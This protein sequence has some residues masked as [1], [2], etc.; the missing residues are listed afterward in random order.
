MRLRRQPS[1]RSPPLINDNL[2]ALAVKLVQQLE[3]R[4]WNA[5]GRLVCDSC[6]VRG[7]D[8]FARAAEEV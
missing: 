2:A 8:A 1:P 3:L 6:R 5:T 7:G 4:F